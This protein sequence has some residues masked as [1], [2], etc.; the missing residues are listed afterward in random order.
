VVPGLSRLVPIVEHNGE[1][2]IGVLPDEDRYVRFYYEDGRRG[3]AAIEEL[4]HGYA[5]FA[6]T[7]LVEMAEYLEE[8]EEFLAAARLL[9]FDQA[10]ELWALCEANDEE[11]IAELFARLA[12]RG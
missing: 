3:D 12:Q 11:G 6:V 2:I 8:K 10:G 1:A 5:Q 7:V 4:G 9:E